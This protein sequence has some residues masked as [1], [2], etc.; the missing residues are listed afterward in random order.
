MIRIIHGKG[1]IEDLYKIIQ[2]LLTLRIIEELLV[3]EEEI[4]FEVFIKVFKTV[5]SSIRTG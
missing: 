2:H 1:H 5:L 3:S 4:E